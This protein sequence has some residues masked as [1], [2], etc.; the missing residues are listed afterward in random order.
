MDK[1]KFGLVLETHRIRTTVGKSSKINIHIHSDGNQEAIQPLFRERRRSRRP[2]ETSKSRIATCAYL[3]RFMF[4]K[5][6]YYDRGLIS[7]SVFV[8]IECAMATRIGI[9][10]KEGKKK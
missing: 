10:Q 7:I 9:T 4:H 6:K 2:M 8:L 5:E 3:T 1:S